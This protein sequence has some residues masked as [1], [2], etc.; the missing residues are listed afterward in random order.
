MLDIAL[1]VRRENRNYI[2][3]SEIFFLG[4]TFL[5]RQLHGQMFIENYWE[6]ILNILF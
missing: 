2:F 6:C 4:L 1:G 3:K 5:D